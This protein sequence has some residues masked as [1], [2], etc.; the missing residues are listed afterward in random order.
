MNM[1][2]LVKRINELAHKA[3]AEG[4]TEDETKE[5]AVLRE[6]YIAAFRKNLCALCLA[7]RQSAVWIPG[8]RILALWTAVIT[9]CHPENYT[10]PVAV[11]HIVL[12]NIRVSHIFTLL[13]VHLS[14]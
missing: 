7:E 5:R 3:K 14:C 4:L 12:G 11:K 1:D 9:S 10:K 2:E 6:Q 8:D 13:P